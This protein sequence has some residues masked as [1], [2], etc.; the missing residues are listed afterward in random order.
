MRQ[1]IGIGLVCV[2]LFAIPKSGSDDGGKVVDPDSTA[3][4]A[5]KVIEQRASIL[6]DVYADASAKVSAGEIKHAT[7][8]AS[9][10]EAGA[11]KANT[12]SITEF[13]LHAVASLPEAAIDDPAATAKWLSAVSEGFGRAA[14]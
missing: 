2:A 9:L 10:L 4:I 7:D 1:I 12:E 13:Q 11:A 5:E 3:A 14:K 6:R 8:L